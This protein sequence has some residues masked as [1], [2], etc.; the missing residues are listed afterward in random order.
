MTAYNGDKINPL[1]DYAFLKA[2]GEPGAEDQLRCFLDQI[3]KKT[4]RGPIT[5]LEILNKHL[6]AANILHGKACIF[7]VDAIA[8]GARVNIEVQLTDRGGTVQRA[9]FNWS[10]L[11]AH[12]IQ[13]GEPYTALPEVIVINILGYTFPKDDN[14]ADFHNSYHLCNDKNGVPLANTME[15][16]IVAMTKFDIYPDKDYTDLFQQWL[17]FLNPNTDEVT[18]NKI[19]TMNPQIKQTYDRLRTAMQDPEEYKIYLR[20]VKYQKDMA[21]ALATGEQRG[22]LTGE[23]EGRMKERIETILA[24]FRA[25]DPVEK[26]AAVVRRSVDEVQE[27]IRRNGAYYQSA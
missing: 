4:R 11:F 13:E 14:D 18:L 25:G 21:T 16:H 27:I 8:D 5:R 26:I 19:L 17:M 2:L 9:L 23:Q 6:N 24:L 10:T 7:D 3:L 22:R 12:D 1:N 20:Q 15:V